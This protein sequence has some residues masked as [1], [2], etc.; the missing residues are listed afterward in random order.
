[1]LSPGTVLGPYE[2]VA[3]IGAGGM[4]EVVS[5]SFSTA[6]VSPD[7]RPRG[8]VASPMSVRP[9]ATAN[10]SDRSLDDIILLL[11]VVGGTVGCLLMPP[12]KRALMTLKNRVEIPAST[13]YDP[14][15]TLE[16][17]LQPG[18]DT[19]RWSSSKAATV[20]GYVVTVQ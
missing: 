2:T 19:H 8:E 5:G 3:F 15:V 9:P 14:A 1:M 17:L 10:W 18:D 20:Q 13:D 16:A 7:G 4:G 6:E 12:D 11:G